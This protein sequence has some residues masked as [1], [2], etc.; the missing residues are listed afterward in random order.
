MSTGDW[1]LV[2]ETLGCRP[3]APKNL[4]GHSTQRIFAVKETRGLQLLL[5]LQQYS[6][7]QNSTKK[8]I[9]TLT[10]VVCKYKIS[11]S[12]I[13]YNFG[14]GGGQTIELVSKELLW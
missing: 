12:H 14:G 3:I 11:D 13:E 6:T 9:W 8:R 1:L 4:P 10:N 7:P 5:F 2:L